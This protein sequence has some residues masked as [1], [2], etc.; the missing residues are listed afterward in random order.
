MKSPKLSSR[1]AKA[2]FDFAGEKNQVE[3][4]YGDLMLFANTLKENRE[5]QVLL[6][7][8]V[9]QP[10]Q[11]HQVFESIFNGTLHDITYQF[12]D[13]LLRKK[14]EP[15]LDTICD[16]FVKMYNAAHNV[17][18]ATITTAEPLSDAL[19]AKILA[20]L[21]EQTGSTIDLKE[22]VCPE[23]IGGFVIQMDDYYLDSS[24]L[25]K[26]NNLR[27]EFSQNTFQVQF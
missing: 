1:Y 11:K 12:L 3:E 15:A 21:S 6:R 17:R 10:H 22:N 9:I 27:R 5:L 18:T 14:R 19:K 25:T 24:I 20:M 23:I 8:P 2:L 13:V 16:E 26:I 7:N 4:V